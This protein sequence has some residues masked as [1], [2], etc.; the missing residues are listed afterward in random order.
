MPVKKESWREILRRC[1]HIKQELSK[2]DVL[3]LPGYKMPPPIIV[4]AVRQSSKPP[5]VII[6][7]IDSRRRRRAT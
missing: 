7:L 3:I 4:V 5:P 6:D 1:A 2:K